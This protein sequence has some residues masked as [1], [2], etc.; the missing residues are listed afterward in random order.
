MSA[1]A[2]TALVAAL[3]AA[4]SLV[5]AA[6]PPGER[7]EPTRAELPVKPTGPIAVEYKLG[8]QP[9]VGVPLEIAVTARVEAEV[10][11]LAIDANASAPN[12]VLVTPPT[13]V[14]SGDGVYSWRLTVVPLAVEAGYLSVIVEGTVD[15]LAQA[16]NVTVALRSAAAGPVPAAAAPGREVFI[17]L[18]V[19]ESP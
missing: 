13:L 6:P 1:R 10:S 5:G 12:A 18:P 8:A 7:S 19:E 4:P 14:A 16:R 11:S 2:A 9:Q 3:L 15:G 17:A